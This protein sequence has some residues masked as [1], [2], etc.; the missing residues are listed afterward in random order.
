ME[1]S[2]CA[3]SRFWRSAWEKEIDSVSVIDNIQQQQR[4]KALFHR[5][6]GS[7]TGALAIGHLSL[8]IHWSLVIGHWSF[9]T[10]HWS[11][12]TAPRPC[13]D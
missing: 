4:R 2:Q 9:F 5:G 6:N 10:G 1:T 13:Q 8:V 7:S 3:I 12:L 11:L